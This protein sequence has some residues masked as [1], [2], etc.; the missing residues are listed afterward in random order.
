MQ[1]IALIRQGSNA[2]RRSPRRHTRQSCST[3]GNFVEM[4]RNKFG[5]HLDPETPEMLDNLQRTVSL[6]IV[7]AVNLGGTVFNTADDSL[8]TVIGPAAAMMRQIAHELLSAYGIA[9]AAE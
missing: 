9:D 3:S 8:R 5:A 2:T 4:T 7:F 6:G 1:E